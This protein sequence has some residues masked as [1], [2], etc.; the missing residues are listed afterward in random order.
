MNGKKFANIFVHFKPVDH[1][2]M[3]EQDANLR[4]R[5]ASRSSGSMSPFSR[6]MGGHE[7][8][9]HDNKSLNRHKEDAER[10]RVTGTLLGEQKKRTLRGDSASYVDV[11]EE[12]VLNVAA[13]KG[14]LYKVKSLVAMDAK[15]VHARDMNG[16]YAVPLPH[17]LL[18]GPH[19]LLPG[20]PHSSPGN[21]STKPSAPAT[22]RS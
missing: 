14:H 16:W 22:R 21:P 6:L 10:Q 11:P 18:P 20:P 8:S 19:L 2:E 9:N 17:L 12:L 1:E 4:R 5:A 13:A 3:N 15:S 7:D